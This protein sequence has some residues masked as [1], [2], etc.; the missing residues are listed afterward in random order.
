MHCGTLAAVD[1]SG[2]RLSGCSI[3]PHTYM[4]PCLL[5]P[6]VVQAEGKLV[7]SEL[8][9]EC[10]RSLVAYL[11]HLK[12]ATRT[13]S[14]PDSA[15]EYLLGEVCRPCGAACCMHGSV[16]VG[17]LQARSS[18]EH[19]PGMC[20]HEARVSSRWGVCVQE[21]RMSSRWA[22]GGK[23][24]SSCAA[25]PAG[26]VR[27]AVRYSWWWCVSGAYHGCC[28]S[29]HMC[30]PPAG[31]H[32][33]LLLVEAAIIFWRGA[34]VLDEERACDVTDCRTLVEAIYDNLDEVGAAFLFFNCGGFAGCAPSCAASRAAVAVE[35]AAVLLNNGMPARWI[36]MQVV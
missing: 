19:S 18:G 11:Q 32:S 2:S 20:G 7:Y 31:E 1:S 26:C 34:R 8:T 13:R 35:G 29:V 15:I 27:P 6:Q 17:C 33:V 5:P 25:P 16:V 21:A 24:V 4:H 14:L 3:R 9:V 12:Q 36:H 10:L 30:N 23:R 28:S 22:C